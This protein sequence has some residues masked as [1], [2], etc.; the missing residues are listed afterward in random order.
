MIAFAFYLVFVLW[1]IND[2]DDDDDDDLVIAHQAAAYVI[3]LHYIN[4][5]FL[6][7]THLVSS[8]LWQINIAVFVAYNACIIYL[9][10]CSRTRPLWPK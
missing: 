7:D 8:Q 10:P 4:F 9:T 1:A 6:S 2:D 3:G 5:V